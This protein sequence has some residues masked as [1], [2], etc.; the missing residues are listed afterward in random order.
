MLPRASA[1][2]ILKCEVPE[3][4]VDLEGGSWS[5]WLNTEIDVILEV[6]KR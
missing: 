3:S 4:W 1:I 5:N 6:L 2:H